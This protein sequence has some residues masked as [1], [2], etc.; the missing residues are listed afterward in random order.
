MPKYIYLYGP[1]G[2]GKTAIALEIKKL[3]PDTIL[4]PFE[5]RRLNRSEFDSGYQGKNSASAAK[6]SPLI[7]SCI[8][9]LRYIYYDLIFKARNIFSNAK[10]VIYTRGILEFG[11]NNSNRRFPGWISL[12]YQRICQRRSVLILTP[13]EDIQRRKNELTLDDTVELYFTYIRTGIQ[14]VGNLDTLEI[15]AEKILKR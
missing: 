2:S 13:I 3:Y 1:D 7:K 15:C 5:P 6:P 12:I 11:I 10:Y 9:F 14:L 4:I 8:L